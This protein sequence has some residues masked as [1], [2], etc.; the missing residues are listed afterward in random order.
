MA[1]PIIHLIAHTHWDREWYLPLGGFRGRLIPV[2]DQLLDGAPV[3]GSLPPFFLDGQTALLRD[4]LALR[5]ERQPDLVDAVTRGRVRTGP[6]SILADEQIPAGEALLR[7]LQLGHQDLDMWRG[8]A[9]VLYSPDAFGHPAA[10]PTIGAEYG[11]ANAVVWRGLDDHRTA[12]RDLAWWRGPDGQQVLVYHLPPEGYEIGS[13]LLVT[14]EELP[15]AW[16]RVAAAVLPRAATPHVAVLVGADHHAPD[17]RLASLADRLTAID[18]GC[19]FRWST[20]EQFFAE[21]RQSLPDLAVIDGELRG[22]YGYTWTLQGVHGTRAPLKRRYSALELT[23]LR[24]VEPLLALAEGA[25]AGARR[26]V[27]QQGWR[28]LVACQF[29][30]TLGGCAADSVARAMAVRLDD[31]AVA[32]ADLE[33]DALHLLVGHDPDAARAGVPSSTRLLVWNGAAR[34]RGGVLVAEGTFF[35][36]DI[37]IGPPGTRR[38]S[39]GPGFQPF[40]LTTADRRGGV[41]PQL[42]AL[43]PAE[44]RRDARR[45]YP[46]QDAVEAV[47]FA[48]PLLD[49][50][51]GL[52]LQAFDVQTG[53]APALEPFVAGNRH[54]IWNGR[55]TATV[56]AR[57]RLELQDP[58]SRAPFPGLLALESERDTGDCYT[59]APLRGD[60]RIEAVRATRPQ[61]F[62][63]GPLVASLGWGV[64]LTGGL[65]A[66]GRT[67]PVR[68]TTD[69]E[70]VGD[71]PVLRCRLRLDNG[72]EHHRLRLRFPTGLRKVPALAGA[73][74][75]Q[76]ARLPVVASRATSMERPVATAPAHRWVAVAKGARGLAIFAP[77]FFEYEWTRSGDLLVTLLRSVGQLSLPDLATRPGHAGWPTA[78]P[79]AQC[80]GNWAIE[81]GLALVAE[82]D[83][84]APERLDA[85]WEDTFVP[86]VTRWERDCTGTITATPRIELS[87]DGLV[88]S[89]CLPADDG[90]GFVLRCYNTRE[91]PVDG[92]WSFGVPIA[93]AERIRADGTV[94]GPLPLSPGGLGVV[95]PVARRGITSVRVRGMAAGG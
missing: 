80:L 22:S 9:G 58:A 73:Q 20:L 72:A 47:R 74:F 93:G 64:K 40:V 71:A 68:L 79:E 56:D 86:P 2:V 19:T 69:I 6:W 31:V 53:A 7:N 77:G 52:S 11:L 30:D 42:L 84:A 25:A 59:F 26:A 33:R 5:P 54:S 87:G 24:R 81:L 76:V 48:I 91:T 46:D 17:P 10:L 37:L 45:H 1:S 65:T 60:R 21:V 13:N 83:L 62:A 28:D 82:D 63:G 27:L 92:L 75:G 51:P 88:F 70:L 43:A 38:P 18:P 36:H 12:G 39:T 95:F 89:A 15:A 34:P 49:A 29:H 16:K 94:V 35:Q 3:G 61:L 44:E 41:A 57:G 55:M 4:Y 67:G 32:A 14:E 66:A 78:T 8:S 23:L 85:W 90:D 50:V